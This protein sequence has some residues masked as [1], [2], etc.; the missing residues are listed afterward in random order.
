M[1]RAEQ[2]GGGDGGNDTVRG[3]KCRRRRVIGVVMTSRSRR[4]R[5]R[6]RTNDRRPS[7]LHVASARRRHGRVAW[8]VARECPRSAGRR[9][10]R[11]RQ[12]VEM[13][14]AGRS[15]A[16]VQSTVGRRRGHGR[17]DVV[18]R[19]AADLTT[20]R[21]HVGRISYR[22]VVVVIVTAAEW[23]HLVPSIIIIIIV[24]VVDVF[25]VVAQFRLLRVHVHVAAPLNRKWRGHVT[26]RTGSRCLS[27]GQWR[28]GSVDV[29]VSYTSTRRHRP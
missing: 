19:P 8:H 27:A 21:F 4:R 25:V 5:R 1:H 20:S 12:V 14:Y 9:R 17:P 13:T 18:H 7:S 6:G 15:S 29:G 23:R 3:V 26:C 28:R 24:V 16:V 2:D 10:Q 22:V 11:Q